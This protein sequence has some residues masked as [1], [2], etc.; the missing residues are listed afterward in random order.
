MNEIQLKLELNEINQILEAL[1][2]Q[3]YAQ[4]FQLI[5]KIQTQAEEQLQPGSMPEPLADDDSGV[6][7]TEAG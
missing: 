5:G 2:T 6:Q 3:P 7:T 4:V 1:G